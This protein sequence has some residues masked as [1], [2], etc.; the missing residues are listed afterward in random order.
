MNK[1][2][3]KR[4]KPMNSL[5][6]IGAAEKIIYL[7]ATDYNEKWYGRAIRGF[8]DPDSKAVFESMYRE[9]YGSSLHEEQGSFPTLIKL[10]PQHQQQFIF[11]STFRWIILLHK[12]LDATNCLC[13]N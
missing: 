9:R 13:G 2:L 8:I 12:I 4:L 5:S 1:E 11:H 7:Q 3:R 10:C 6:H